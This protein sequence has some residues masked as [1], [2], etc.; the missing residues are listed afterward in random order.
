MRFNNTNVQLPTPYVVAW[1]GLT[2]TALE[3]DSQIYFTKSDDGNRHIFYSYDAES[4]EE[5]PSTSSTALQLNTGD[6]IYCRA[7]FTGTTN[8]ISTPQFKLPAGKWKVNGKLNSLFY[9]STYT[10]RG[11]NIPTCGTSRM[12]YGCSNL[13]DVSELDFCNMTTVGT[14]MPRMFYNCN[15]I[16]RV[17]CN[18]TSAGE[19]SIQYLF[20]GCNSLNYVSFPNL[21]D[22]SNVGSTYGIFLNTPTTG[23]FVKHPNANWP[24]GGISGIPTGWTLITSV[25]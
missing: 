25:V 4:W 24:I 17:T 20:Y 3:D 9:N 10:K 7:A 5:M 8:Y 11:T 15:N 12:F 16:T 19:N 13:Y 22:L 14:T 2:F 23:T 6:V 18:I 1:D 21:A